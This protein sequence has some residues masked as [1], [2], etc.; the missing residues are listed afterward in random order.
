ME[1]K[2]DLPTHLNTHLYHF[3]EFGFLFLLL[4]PQMLFFL[5]KVHVTYFLHPNGLKNQQIPI[6]C[7]ADQAMLII[8][9]QMMEWDNSNKVLYTYFFLLD[10]K[11]Y[12]Y[13]LVY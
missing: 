1:Y 11:D 10:L 9:V 13:L 2:E 12:L 6:F 5:H 8:I 7:N 4:Y 3:L